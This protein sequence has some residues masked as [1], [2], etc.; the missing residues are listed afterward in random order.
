MKYRSKLTA[1]QQAL[2]DLMRDIS[3]R[4]YCAGWLICL[5]DHLWDV[6]SQLDYTDTP[7][8]QDVITGDDRDKLAWLAVACGGW[9]YWDDETC[10]TFMPIEARKAQHAK[11][12]RQ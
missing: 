4:C 8:G 12:A 7:W 3:E 11:G 1:D 5:E 6:V 2:A 9:I 10:E